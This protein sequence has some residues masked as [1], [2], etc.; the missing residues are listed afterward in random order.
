MADPG[1]EYGAADLDE[2]LTF[3]RASSGTY[4]N[5]S[6]VL[7]T[8]ST[9][10]MRFD[11]DPVTLEPLGVLIE[12]ARTNVVLY[13]RDLT[14][15]AWT[16]TNVTAAKNQ[17]GIDGVASSASSITATAGNGTCLQTITLGS[18][19]RFQTAYVKRIT[20]TGTIEMTMDNGSTWTAI[21]ITSSWTRVSIPTQTLANPTVGFRIVTSGDSIAVDY[22]QNENGAF[23]SSAILATTTAVARSADVLTTAVGSWFNA[24]EG[25]LIAEWS[26]LT[27]SSGRRA[28]AIDDG[29]ANNRFMISAATG[30]NVIQ[31]A[32]RVSG[33]DVASQSFGAITPDSIEKLALAYKL[34]DFAFSSNGSAA[35]TDT[36]GALPGGLTTV[37]FGS[38]SSGTQLF[39]YLRRVF[40]I[41]RRVSNTELRELSK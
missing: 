10:V 24:S 23:P 25:A 20:G 18:S 4:F 11:Y 19:A 37:R 15:A 38:D 1:V 31:G 14:N 33:S 26:V 6:G 35:V 16:K 39:G 27:A 5:S 29:T 30:G 28:I 2:I 9:D 7:T 36:S 40:Y 22:V 12:G 32:V 13:N 21:T 3:T 41:P 17:T 34:N 8:A